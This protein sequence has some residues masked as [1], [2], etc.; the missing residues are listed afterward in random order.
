VRI[1]RIGMTKTEQR[2]IDEILDEIDAVEEE[3]GVISVILVDSEVMKIL[4]D[5]AY[6]VSG[7][8]EEDGEVYV[9]GHLV[10]EEDGMRGFYVVT[11]LEA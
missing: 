3:G 6:H 10:H 2:V 5:K 4:R 9:Y 8:S 11:S 1:R 7:I